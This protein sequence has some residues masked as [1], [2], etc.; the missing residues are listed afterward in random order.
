MALPIEDYALIGDTETA[1]L[2]GIDGS[3]DWLCLPRFDEPA[4][5][6][7]LLGDEQNGH[8]RLAPEAADATGTR[9]YRG[10]TLV[11]ET[12]FTTAGGTVTVVDFMPIRER[13]PTV[14]RVV[15]GRSGVVRMHTDLRIRFDYGSIVPWV[16][17]I[18]GGIVG[19]GGGDAVVVRASVP[20][21]GRDLTTVSTFDVAA[22]D[23]V[24]FCMT[25]FP[26]YDAV[27]IADDIGDPLVL[28][29][30]TEAWWRD[31]AGRAN[32]PDEWADAARRSLITLKALTFAPTGGIVAAPTTSLP[33]QIGG[34]RNWD[35]RYCWLRD[36][37]F[38][39]HALLDAGYVHEADAWNRWLRRAVAGSPDKLQIMYGVTGYRRLTEDELDWLPGYEG[40]AP[41]RVGNAASEQFQLDV[42][43][44][45]LDMLLTASTA[46]PAIEDT[47]AIY[48][49]SA[50]S[51]TSGGLWDLAR[52]LVDH[53]RK[54][55]TEPDE[56][57]WEVRGPRRHFV[58]SKVMAWV[59]V[60]HWV[61]MVGHALAEGL[62]VDGIRADADIEPW[63]ELCEQIHA[64][65][66]EQGIDPVRGC[67]TQFYGSSQVD[68]SLLMLSLV[69]FL[70][71]DDPRIIAT[72]EAIEADLLVDGFVLRYRTDVAPDGSPLP[73]DDSGASVDGL[74]PGEGAFLLTTFWLVDNLVMLGRLDDARD[75]FEALL[76]L[77]NDVGLLSEEWDVVDGRMVGNFPQAFSHVGLLNSAGN[78]ARGAEGPAA[79]RAT[80][81]HRAIGPTSGPTGGPTVDD[82]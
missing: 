23:R 19:I 14:I 59:A 73:G 7:A 66:C 25:W 81:V 54:V 30:R 58:H 2:V 53:V 51:P 16:R 9:C 55:W 32:V 18:E 70:P 41:V 75:R 28:M 43:G 64:D 45:T 35:Y 13:L 8:W 38:T 20:L 39:L 49:E 48:G 24:W 68:A 12:E 76:A 60:D 33:E 5:F 78:L 82:S 26:S 6:A 56:G 63:R 62:A 4:C 3:I 57:I 34:P 37:T 21:E 65:V 10:D 52:F 17:G 29:A 71:P 79:R 46:L 11:L 61:R 15:E 80:A 27:P 72:V 22:D 69:G 44:E 47:A 36:A 74:P 42:Y 50:N 1:A 67:F 40:S 77:R 31:W